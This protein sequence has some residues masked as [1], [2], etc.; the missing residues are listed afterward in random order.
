M[1][2]YRA[3]EVKCAI[4]HVF[5]CGGIAAHAVQYKIGPLTVYELIRH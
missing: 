3:L 2:R 5:G 4:F 1:T